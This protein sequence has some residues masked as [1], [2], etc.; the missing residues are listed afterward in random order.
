[1]WKYAEYEKSVGG[2]IETKYFVYD[3]EVYQSEDAVKLALDLADSRAVQPRAMVLS[4]REFKFIGEIN[5]Q[6]R[7]K[8]VDKIRKRLDE[9]KELIDLGCGVGAYH[10]VGLDDALEICDKVLEEN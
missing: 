7:E 6:V 5:S 4:E 8:T 9:E 2:Y 3:D 1:M 10:F